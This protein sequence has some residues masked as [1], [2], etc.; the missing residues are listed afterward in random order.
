MQSYNLIF[1]Y[2]DLKLIF[3]NIF[4]THQYK[5]HEINVL[6]F[7]RAPASG[8]R[9]ISK[10]S[11]FCITLNHAHRKSAFRRVGLSAI[12]FCLPVHKTNTH[13]KPTD[14]SRTTDSPQ[15]HRRQ[16]DFRYNPSRNQRIM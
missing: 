1:F 15:T 10:P 11:E 14:T 9:K 13:P 3:F 2:C 12:I 7:G 16:K 4:Q 8:E 5:A 6:N